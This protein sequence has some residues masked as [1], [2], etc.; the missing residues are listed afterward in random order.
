MSGYHHGNLRAATLD[1]GIALVSERGAGAL[2]IRALA[3]ELGVS[4]AALYRHFPDIEH[5]RA[6]VSRIARE[7]LAQ[8]MI[9]AREGASGSRDPRT[10]AVRRFDAIGSAYIDVAT[11]QPRLFDF[12]FAGCEAP[13]SQPDDPDAGRCCRTRSTSSVTPACSSPGRWSAPASSRGAACTAWRA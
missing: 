8:A 2:G 9:V 10:A 13:P 3:D 5:V 6:D 11:R 1:A 4:S 7:G 12:A